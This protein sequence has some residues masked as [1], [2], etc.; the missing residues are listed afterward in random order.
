MRPTILLFLCLLLAAAPRTE[1]LDGNMPD[2][3]CNVQVARVRRQ[4]TS[5]HFP[6]VLLK[7]EARLTRNGIRNVG[8]MS[9]YGP[10][11]HGVAYGDYWVCVYP[12]DAAR[13]R[14]LVEAA[15]REGWRI[16]PDYTPPT[17]VCQ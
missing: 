13:A 11:T 1:A 10:D 7:M 8:S 3:F 15:R 5:R 16:E 12:P 17:P 4:G 14:Q 9:G 2:P 6:R